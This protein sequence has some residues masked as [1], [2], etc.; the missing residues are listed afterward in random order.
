MHLRHSK[1]CS[2]SADPSIILHSATHHGNVC[3]QHIPKAQHLGA[4]SCP[5]L[6]A[7]TAQGLNSLTLRTSELFSRS[8][9]NSHT[10]PQVA[11]RWTFPQ[12]T[13]KLNI[14]VT[15]G[16]CSQSQ[17]HIAGLQCNIPGFCLSP[18]NSPSNSRLESPPPSTAVRAQNDPLATSPLSSAN[19]FLI[20]EGYCS[21]KFSLSHLKASQINQNQ[22]VFV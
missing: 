5:P 15:R 11:A 19:C 10:K 8:T 12:P 16:H 7:S 18:L 4:R 2:T 6:A 1:E 22:D 13:S 21:S 9:S 17:Q 3:T 20:P 14:Q